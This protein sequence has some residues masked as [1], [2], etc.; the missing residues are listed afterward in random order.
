MSKYLDLIEAPTRYL[1]QWSDELE[2]VGSFDKTAQGKQAAEEFVE[3]T[4]KAEQ[5]S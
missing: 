4:L 2:V 3:E 1:V 5:E